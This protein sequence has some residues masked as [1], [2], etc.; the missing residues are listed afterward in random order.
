MALHLVPCRYSLFGIGARLL[1]FGPLLRLTLK[2][3]PWFRNTNFG[4]AVH[5]DH[6]YPS[7][8]EHE[9]RA[10]GFSGVQIQVSWTCERFF[11]GV[12]PVYLLHAAYEQVVRRLRIRRLASYA[13]IS[14]VR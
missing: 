12:Y 3:A 11:R 4:W 6:C 7:A 8:L 1:P 5:Y 14:A 9:F 10:A 13:I 2:L